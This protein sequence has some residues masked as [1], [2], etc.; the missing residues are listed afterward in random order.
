MPPKVKKKGTSQKLAQVL[1]TQR[2][3]RKVRVKLR[4]L[5]PMEK[6]IKQASDKAAAAADG[7][8]RSARASGPAPVPPQYFTDPTWGLHTAQAGGSSMTVVLG[9]HA[10]ESTHYGSTPAANTPS[11]MRKLLDEFGAYGWIA[12]HLLNDN[13]G[14][15]G[16]ARNL[17]P[18]TTAGNKNH[19]NGCETLI[20]NTIAKAASRARNYRGD[21]HWYG[22][23][24]Q[25]KVSD[26]KYDALGV[27]DGFPATI[28]TH[29]LVSA[30]VVRQHKQTLV[31]SDLPAA[32]DPS[33]IYFAPFVDKRIENVMLAVDDAA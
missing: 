6:A 27:D 29:L 30:K 10:G 17:T 16:V 9:P 24:Y 23:S 31:V 18:L 13:L 11:V 20:K 19:L 14:G 3:R 32:E 2:K 25:V 7:R 1:S 4:E 15:A 33:E 5:T 12:G 26:E 21:E 22:V 28:A 8:R